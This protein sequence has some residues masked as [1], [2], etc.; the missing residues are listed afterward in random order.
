[1][2]ADF[3]LA[4]IEKDIEKL[5]A[6]NDG[7]EI[8]LRSLENHDATFA[9]QLLAVSDNVKALTAEMRSLRR[10]FIGFSVT[11]A[12]AAISFGFLMLAAFR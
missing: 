6:D 7:F 12:G 9:A 10:S 8:R 5:T 4:R 2:D 3:R 11:F 1:M